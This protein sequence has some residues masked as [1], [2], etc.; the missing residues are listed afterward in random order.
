MRLVVAA[1]LSLP[2]E[3]VEQQQ[4]D[5]SLLSRSFMGSKPFDNGLICRHCV[6][7]MWLLGVLSCC[8]LL[9]I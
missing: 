9:C 8:V 6:V 3:T 7:N 1:L 4:K 2:G 5:E